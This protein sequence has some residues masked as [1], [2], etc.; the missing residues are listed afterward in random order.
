M[1]VTVAYPFVDVR[2]DTRDLAP[3]AQRS[4]GVIAVVGKT[5]AANVQ[6]PAN[7]PT[8][9]DNDAIALEL[10]GENVNAPGVAPN[11]TPLTL[12]LRDA[13]KQDPRPSKVYGVRVDA[14]GNYAA[15]L[16]S[17]EAR[18]DVT[19]VALANEVAVGAASAP[20]AAATGLMA[21]SEHIESMAA[22]GSKRIGVAMVDPGTAR[23]PTYA[24]DVLNTMAPLRN[25]RDRMIV[26]AARNAT[27]DAAAATMGM[28]AG[29]E[30]QVSAVLKQVRGVTIPLESQFSA[31]EITALSVGGINPI[32]DPILIPGPGFYLG[33]GRTFG[34]GDL[35]YIDIVRVLDDI[36]FQLKAGLVGLIGDAR[37]TRAG[38]T[39]LKCRVDGILGV[40]KRQ[41]V[42]DDYSIRIPVGEILDRPSSTWSAADQ[43]DVVR[44][45][46]NRTVPLFVIVAYGPAVHLLR[47]TLK[48][49][50]GAA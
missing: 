28:I 47:I 26:V 50:L 8:V 24:A 20:G 38:M 29:F 12:S 4:P 14:A 22:A 37:I 2:I 36:E 42:I 41:A 10:F 13:M 7:V 9:I 45:R 35:T 46:Q 39:Q 18:D 33:D 5:P 40:Y 3:V 43:A 6:V 27:G 15:A 44:A 17:L 32:I 21:L 1:T 11:A 19:F 48:P 25:S 34:S 49:T 16:T 31:S 23:S 30:P